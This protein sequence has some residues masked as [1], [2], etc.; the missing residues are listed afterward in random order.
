[1]LIELRCEKILFIF[2]IIHSTMSEYKMVLNNRPT[3]TIL[4][5][6]PQ[7]HHSKNLLHPMYIIPIYIICT[8]PHVEEVVPES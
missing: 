7:K 8:L 4:T 1:M 6:Q 2:M 3:M 5:N